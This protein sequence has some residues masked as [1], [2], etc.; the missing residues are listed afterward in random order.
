[1]TTPLAPAPEGGAAAPQGSRGALREGLLL[2]PN[3]ARLIWGL[4]RDSRVS[5]VDKALVVGALAYFVMPLDFVP[6]VIPIFG[7]LDDAAVLFLTVR[8]LLR[9]T[10]SEVIAAHWKGDPAWL[11][12]S[13]MARMLGVAAWIVPG[14]KRR[15][16]AKREG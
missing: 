8:R 2:L 6:D 13:G 1:M 9:R 12:D 16:K 3:L 11:T 4:A 7:E 14:A 10:N 5:L 15:S